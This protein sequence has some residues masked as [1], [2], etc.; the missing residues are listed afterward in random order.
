MSARM[1]AAIA[2]STW[3]LRGIVALVLLGACL[4]GPQALATGVLYAS[5]SENLYRL[6]PYTGAATSVGSFDVGLMTGLGWDPISG[7]MYGTSREGAGGLYTVNLSTGA[8]TLV[9]P[10][11]V[12]LH[13]LE[14]DRWTGTLFGA[15]GAG[16]D[17]CL[18]SINTATGAAALLGH[19]GHFH[20]S[21][22]DTVGG[23][24][25]SPKTGVLY[26][27]DNGSLI[28][29]GALV[30][31]N[32]A[33]GAGTLVGTCTQHIDGL[34]FDPYTGV[35]YGIDNWDGCLYTIDLD[36]GQTTLAGATGLG[37]G[38]GLAFTF[39]RGDANGDGAVDSGDLSLMAAGWCQAPPWGW[40]NG[41]FNG[42]K[43]VDAGDLALIAMEWGR[44]NLSP[45]P[46]APIPEPG[47][48]AILC[49]GALAL[50]RRRQE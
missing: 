30:T 16:A 38:L 10:H 45:A 32:K 48:L 20:E 47:S 41:D 50:V 36:T 43:Q 46:N 31:I 44:V 27:A 40:A 5:D 1:V 33:T 14:Y 13:G 22:L 7:V 29:W 18:Y 34:A 2:R 28:G 12:K 25:V 49:L 26:G 11:G 3:M 35:L 42:D 23:L 4:G 39:Y 8:A 37:N 6:T 19:I 17:D 21:S 24:A 15:Y 9:G